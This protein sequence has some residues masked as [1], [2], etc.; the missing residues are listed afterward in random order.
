MVALALSCSRCASPRPVSSELGAPSRPVAAVGGAP[1]TPGISVAQPGAIER[2]LKPWRPTFLASATQA[3]LVFDAPEL[4]PGRELS[5]V[6]V[7]GTFTGWGKALPLQAQADGTWQAT[8]SRA[9]LGVPGNSGT[10]EFQ[11]LLEGPTGTDRVGG[12]LAPSGQRFANNFV[13]LWPEIT[14]DIIAQ[15]DGQNRHRRSDFDSVSELA[16]FR[17]LVGGKLRRGRLYRSYHPFVASQAGAI[18]TQRLSAVQ[19]LMAEIKISAVINLS[20]DI[21]IINRPQTP[22]YYRELVDKGRVLFAP[23]HYNTVY[24][25]SSGSEFDGV[26]L[27]VLSFMAEQPGPYLIHCRLGTDRTGVVSAILQVLAEVPWPTI[28][29]DFQRSNSLGMEEYRA[30]EL[31]TY[32]IAQFLG[33]SPD[34]IPA[35]ELAALLRSRLQTIASAQIVEQ[36]LQRVIR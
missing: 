28:V 33:R 17:E 12:S 27:Q 5:A 35:R 34:H 32:S 6:A 19:G 15:R 11:F 16:N 20:D 4:A 30:P 29:E 22:S 10:T 13:I 9:V 18:E 36:A 25:D 8:F 7:T 26:I 21:E 3:T 14:A 31:L 1:G 2:A 24:F 23:T